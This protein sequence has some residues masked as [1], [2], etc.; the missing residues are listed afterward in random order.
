MKSRQVLR[1]RCDITHTPYGCDDILRL[2]FHNS[3]KRFECA[4]DLV[5]FFGNKHRGLSDALTVL[6]KPTRDY[7]SGKHYYGMI[8]EV[9]GVLVRS[10]VLD[11]VETPFGDHLVLSKRL[12]VWLEDVGKRWRD[13]IRFA[14]SPPGIIGS[15][16]E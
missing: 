3:P 12:G 15:L 6:G 7:P 2:L 16:S 5:H 1:L 8:E 4:R 14:S 10:G 13:G 11:E 9:G